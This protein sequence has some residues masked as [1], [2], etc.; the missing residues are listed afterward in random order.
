MRG[1][2]D[3]GRP[4]FFLEDPNDLVVVGQR[5]EQRLDEAEAALAVLRDQL[6]RGDVERIDVDLAVTDD[7]VPS[8][9]EA[10]DAK[11]GQ[12]HDGPLIC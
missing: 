3:K 4:R 8:E 5:V 9:L 1:L 2:A 10:G 6:K 11:L 12:A 7:P